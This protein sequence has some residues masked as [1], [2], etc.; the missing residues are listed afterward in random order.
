[1][2]NTAAAGSSSMIGSETWPQLSPAMICCK[3]VKFDCITLE[4]A[5]WQRSQSFQMPVS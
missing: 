2:R 5:R 1:M 4:K 3:K